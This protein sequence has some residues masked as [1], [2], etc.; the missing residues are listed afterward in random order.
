M[1]AFRTT[2]AAILFLVGLLGLVFAVVS[3]FLENSSD[4]AL[5]ITLFASVA[6]GISRTICKRYARQRD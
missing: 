1:E 5:V 2:T 3:F 6:L 4:V